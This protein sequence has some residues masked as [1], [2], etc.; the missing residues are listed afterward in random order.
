MSGECPEYGTDFTLAIFNY[1]YYLHYVSNEWYKLRSYDNHRFI[2]DFPKSNR[3][4]HLLWF[5]AI[6]AYDVA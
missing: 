5:I 2:N 4:W 3:G 6:D 1:L